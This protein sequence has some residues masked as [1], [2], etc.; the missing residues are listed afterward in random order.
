MYDAL[1]GAPFEDQQE[2]AFEDTEQQQQ[3]EEG[4]WPLIMLVVPII[5]QVFT[6]TLYACISI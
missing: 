5:C 1:D 3:F 6:F 4:K 2:R